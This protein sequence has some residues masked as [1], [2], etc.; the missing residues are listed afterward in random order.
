MKMDYY[1]D[2]QFIHIT[3]NIKDIKKKNILQHH[4]PTFHSTRLENMAQRGEPTPTLSHIP[5]TNQPHQRPLHRAREAQEDLL[6]PAATTQ[7]HLLSD[8]SAGR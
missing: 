4:R 7:A 5:T 1:Q 6:D 8:Q 2:E 3:A